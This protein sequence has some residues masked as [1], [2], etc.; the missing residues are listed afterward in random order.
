MHFYIYIRGE[1]LKHN[2]SAKCIE[3][4]LSESEFMDE[5]FIYPSYAQ[6]AVFQWKHPV[7]GIFY[8]DQIKAFKTKFVK[9]VV[10]EECHCV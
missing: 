2:L 5:C 9:N 3:K 10:D 6:K 8:T 1:L 7:E 4:I